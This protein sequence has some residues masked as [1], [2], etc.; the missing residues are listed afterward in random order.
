MQGTDQNPTEYDNPWLWRG[1]P[2][3]DS[4]G[5]AG[6]VYMITNRD[7]RKRYVGKKFLW[8][9]GPRKGRS[10]PIVH[11]DWR[12]YYG[13]SRLLHEQVKNVERERFLREILSL[14]KTRGATNYYEVWELFRRDVLRDASYMNDA[15]GKYARVHLDESIFAEDVAWST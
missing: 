10:R 14:H 8:R 7:T 2:F 1:E 5:W 11:S 4:S 13:S 12:R 9:K 15:I 3:L 6:F